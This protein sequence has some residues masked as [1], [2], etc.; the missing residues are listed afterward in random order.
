MKIL[1]PLLALLFTACSSTGGFQRMA[2]GEIGC[3]PK[4]IKVSNA[5]SKWVLDG[6]RTFQAECDGITYYC[7]YHNHDL[8]NV[9][10]KEAKPKAV[11]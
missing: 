6:L 3:P 2:S 7:S 10:C 9:R 11:E 1:I 5:N 4:Q 8:G